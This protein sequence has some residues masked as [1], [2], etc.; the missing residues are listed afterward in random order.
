MEGS[1][2]TKFP[3]PH[4]CPP[5][6]LH[7]REAGASCRNRS[8]EGGRQTPAALAQRLCSP[9]ASGLRGGQSRPMQNRS[10]DTSPTPAH[11][12]APPESSVTCSCC[13][14]DFPEALGSLAVVMVPGPGRAAARGQVRSDGEFRAT[15]VQS[16]GRGVIQSILP[17][18]HG[19]FGEG[20]GGSVGGP[21]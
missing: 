8:Q 12:H 19:Y 21:A 4:A 5:A 15:G 2:R 17:K 10:G 14:T 20:G 13:C 18:S 7:D 1:P 6:P 9:P 16:A 11:A 3:S